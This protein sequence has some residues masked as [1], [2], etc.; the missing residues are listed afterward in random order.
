MATAS[1]MHRK[2]EQAFALLRE[3][4]TAQETIQPMGKDYT[5]GWVLIKGKVSYVNSKPNDSDYKS[6]TNV[7]GTVVMGFDGKLYTVNE[8]WG[9][10]EGRGSFNDSWVFEATDKVLVGETGAP[11]SRICQA[12]DRVIALN[13]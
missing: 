2:A 13:S 11:F 6:W 7:M 8:G 4:P 12:L 10:S 9:Y 1:E 3:N 5:L